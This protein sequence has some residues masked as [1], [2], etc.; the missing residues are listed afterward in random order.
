MQSFRSI[1]DFQ[2]FL[3]SEDRKNSNG[4]NKVLKSGE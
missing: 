2:S 1:G 4:H 3:D